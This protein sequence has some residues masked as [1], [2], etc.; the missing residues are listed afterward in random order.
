MWTLVECCDHIQDACT[1][2][3]STNKELKNILD[4]VKKALPD[5]STAYIDEI[6][7][8]LTTATALKYSIYDALNEGYILMD[9]VH[10]CF[11]SLATKNQPIYPL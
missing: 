11:D 8:N 5:P 9:Q 1:R 4:V 2:L 3:I 10:D 7:Q 6:E